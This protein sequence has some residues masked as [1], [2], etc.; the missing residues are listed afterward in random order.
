MSSY[1]PGILPLFAAA[2]LVAAAPVHAADPVSPAAALK[3][4]DQA[5]RAAGGAEALAG[6]GILQAEIH[7]EEVTAKGEQHISDF[8]AWVNGG[9]VEQL[10]LQLNPQVLLVD[11][12]KKSWAVVKGELDTRRQTPLMARMTLHDRL[13]PLLLPFSLEVEGIRA[14]S[15]SRTTWEGDAVWKLTVEFPPN[16]FTTPILNTPWEIMVRRSDGRVVM[17]QLF[18][19]EEYAKIGAEGMRYRFLGWATVGPV[20]LPS[21]L[22]IVGID[23]NGAESGHV[24]T[25][26]IRWK[27]LGLPDEPLFMHPE[28]LEALDEGDLPGR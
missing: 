20:R 3:V 25:V 4:V 27:A 18:A 8:T 26:K 19:P 13:F 1:R 14:T 17:A 9:N 16:Y 15:V 21:D 7:N 10:R 28:D 12:G 5:V 11:N 24:R 22:L 23:T 6:L 2:A